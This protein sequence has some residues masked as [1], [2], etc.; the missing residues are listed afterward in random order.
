MKPIAATRARALFANGI[1][2]GRRNTN[3]D[4]A[5]EIFRYPRI[6]AVNGSTETRYLASRSNFNVISEKRGG[7]TGNHVAR[8]E[9]KSSAPPRAID[10]VNHVSLRETGR[11]KE[12][13]RERERKRETDY[14][15]GNQRRNLAEGKQESEHRVRAFRSITQLIHARLNARRT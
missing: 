3:R 14:S 1:R 7:I 5:R 6:I 11:E 8:D 4:C 9:H 2:D 10:H 13:E 15:C 12:R